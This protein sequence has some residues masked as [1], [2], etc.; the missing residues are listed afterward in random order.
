LRLVAGSLAVAAV[1]GGCGRA[2]T[3]SVEEDKAAGEIAYSAGYGLDKSIHVVRSDGSGAR[4][5]ARGTEGGPAWSSDGTQLAF[6]RC[7]E[8]DS[9]CTIWVRDGD[10]ERKVSRIDLAVDPTWSPDGKE[11][12]FGRCGDTG[13]GACAMFAVPTKAEGG[14][15]RR[16]TKDGLY[17]RPV[18]SPD[19]NRLALEP[20]KAGASHRGIVVVAAD[21]SGVIWSTQHFD[22]D[23]QWSPDG[24][25]IAFV[26]TA[27]LPRR[28][29][30]DVYV[31]AADG[32]GARR[33]TDGK[34]S[35]DS[36][37]W[38]PAGDQ[39]VF[40][41]WA[42]DDSVSCP[43]SALFAAASD[44]SN[45]RQLT[46][47]GPLSAEPAW[48]PDGRWIAFARIDKCG[49]EEGP[50]LSLIAAEG[51]NARPISLVTRLDA[52][53][54]ARPPYEIAFAWRPSP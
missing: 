16:V 44:G 4:E 43:S 3:S 20:G 51:D 37:A 30:R 13:Q 33:I 53:P 18:W 41:Q 38:S 6:L 54:V 29:R 2:W 45:R 39:I 32:T 5:V 12:A 28:A 50:I 52:S 11:I 22:S 1:V 19:G 7:N 36:P 35:A 9:T 34:T 10:G 48:S 31:I 14:R 27:R 46:R 8:F 26:R 17:G 49:S 47:Y 25:R 15:P 23:P 24:R 42:G 21:G 40:T